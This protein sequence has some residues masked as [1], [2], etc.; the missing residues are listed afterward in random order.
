MPPDAGDTFIVAPDERVARN[1]AEKREARARIKR[2]PT[3][4]H[5]TLEDFHARFSG[6]EKKVLYMIIK[7][8]VQGSVDVL[9]SSFAKIGNE[10][11]S[12][13]V[14]HAGVGGI[15]ESDVL[16]AEASD[17]VII[18][19]HVTA[20]AKVK[21][22]AEQAGVEIRSYRIIY[23]ALDE[24]RSALEGMLAPDM[25]EVVT[26]HAEVREVF[27]SSAMGNIAGCYQTDGEMARG[28]LARVVRD[29]VIVYEGQINSLR[30]HKEDV[31]NVATG[32]E[33][34]VKL[35]RFEDVRV[36]DVIET[37]K[38]ESVAKTLEQESS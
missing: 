8:D 18:G 7:A 29:S 9:Q 38:H 36:G 5:M 26:G 19:F 20:N 25:R 32:F 22:M 15:S 21:K 16:L 6:Q 1:I 31:R 17:A 11:V 33:C 4:R 30:R 34:G 13:N 12:I 27:H 23:E 10:E 24:V 37:F 2:G 14:V 28:A 3:A 35:E